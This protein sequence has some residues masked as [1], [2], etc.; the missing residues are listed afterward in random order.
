MKQSELMIKIII[1]L[2]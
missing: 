2:L 1:L